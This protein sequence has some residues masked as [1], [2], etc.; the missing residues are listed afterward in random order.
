MKK[1]KS[2]AFLAVSIVL[3]I[4]SGIIRPEGR[5]LLGALQT[6]LL[7]LG[8]VG[9]CLAAWRFAKGGKNGKA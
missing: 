9:C 4:I 2:A 6:I 8:L 7:G 1:G 5:E 3:I